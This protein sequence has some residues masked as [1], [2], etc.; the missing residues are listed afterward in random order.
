MDLSQGVLKNWLDK[1]KSKMNEISLKDESPRKGE[2]RSFT[3]IDET[4]FT[5]ELE[6]GPKHTELLV[7]SARIKEGIYLSPLH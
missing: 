1:A 6:G 4:Y 5:F 3:Q 7:A 2:K